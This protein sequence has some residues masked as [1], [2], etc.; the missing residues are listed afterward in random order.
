MTFPQSLIRAFAVALSCVYVALSHAALPAPIAA[1]LRASGV[2][3]NALSLYVREVGRESAIIDHRATSAMNPASTMKLVTTLVGLDVLSPNYTW[4]TEF[5]TT[6]PAKDGVLSGPLIIR[7]SGDPKF[8]WEHLQAAIKAL[9]DSGVRD[10]AG[11][12]WLD[13][14][15][16]A[17]VVTDPSQ[18]DGQPLR[19]YNVAPDALLYNYKTVGFKF[20]P[21]PDNTVAI[22]TDGPVPDGLTLINGLRAVSGPCGD[23]RATI[24]PTFDNSS[25]AV[26]ASFTGTYAVDCGDRDWYVSVFDHTGLLA[27]SFARMWRDAGGLWTGLMREGK[28]PK[29]ARV[30]YTH[31]SAPLSSMVTDINKFSNNVMARQLLLTFEAELAK[32]PGRATRG[33][34]TVREWAKTRGFDVPDLV[35]ENGSGL[36][37]IER[38]SAK[39][40]AKF[41]EYGLTAPFSSQFVM[42]LPIAATDGTLTKRF[43]NQAAE[44]NAYLKTGT[45]TGVRALSGYLMLPG[46]RLVVFVAM[47]NHPKADAGVKA[48][49]AAVDWVFQNAGTQ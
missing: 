35:I 8:S 41:L 33:G 34:R 44:G 46:K 11:D 23:W 17:A 47:I 7:G 14:S 1:S 27:G 21:Q 16:F 36:S 3:P 6:S 12:V 5:L 48:M 39:T 19:P 25:N 10:I 45:L 38:I 20:S 9:R 32:S 40:M 29:G 31:T 15:R 42:S 37:R 2:P 4:K 18:F 30:R 26:R 24:I 28:T 22:T 43:N 13:R 49:D